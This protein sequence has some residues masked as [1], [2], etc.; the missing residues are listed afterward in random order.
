MRTEDVDS[1]SAAPDGAKI[2]AAN[3]INVKSWEEYLE[4]TWWSADDRC[5][6][7]FKEWDSHLQ[8]P[9]NLGKYAATDKRGGVPPR[10]SPNF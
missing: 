3:G 2:V 10:S 8:L 6:T 5:R 9:L 1:G 7:R 4:I